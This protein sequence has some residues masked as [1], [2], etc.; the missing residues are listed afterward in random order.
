MSCRVQC[1]F[2]TRDYASR[3][4]RRHHL[5]T[6][7]PDQFTKQEVLKFQ[8]DMTDKLERKRERRKQG[9]EHTSVPQLKDNRC[10]LPPE[11][12]LSTPE[13]VRTRQLQLP[14]I[15]GTTVDDSAAD[16]DIHEEA[17]AASSV[18]S[19]GLEDVLREFAPV[20]TWSPVVL[21]E[22][23][24]LMEVLSDIPN[25]NRARS[26]PGLKRKL[27][28]QRSPSVTSSPSEDHQNA[29][30]TRIKYLEDNVAK[31]DGEWPWSFMEI[32]SA[33]L[34]NPAVTMMELWRAVVDY[35][36]PSEQLMEQFVHDVA[37]AK[38]VRKETLDRVNDDIAAQLRRGD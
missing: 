18:V 30:H 15:L 21:D 5:F 2:C 12:Q 25:D 36:D 38:H 13:T 20:D 3:H 19:H 1:Y 16:G 14:K 24:Q 26:P 27:Q 29:Y 33:I 32:S 7:H 37:L 8:A 22:E 28:P 10:V 6:V 34:E 4:G 11:T 9:K 31:V 17:I 23:R 35:D